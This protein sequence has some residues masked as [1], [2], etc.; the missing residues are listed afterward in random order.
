MDEQE[1]RGKDGKLCGKVRDKRYLVIRRG[2]R[3][4]VFDLK[5]VVEQTERADNDL[6]PENK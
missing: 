4:D 6:K 5:R 1:L 2:K 3:I